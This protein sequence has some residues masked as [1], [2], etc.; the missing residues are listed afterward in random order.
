MKLPDVS[1][2]SVRSGVSGVRDNTA[3]VIKM[4]MMIPAQVIMTRE[5]HGSSVYPSKTDCG[6]GC[7]VLLFSDGQLVFEIKSACSFTMIYD[8]NVRSGLMP[9]F[10][11]I[12]QVFVNVCMC[13][14]CVRLSPWREFSMCV[15]V[16]WCE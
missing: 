6:F 8:K 2:R 13:D 4:I 10:E 1:L 5:K 9:S 11:C 16:C 7:A 3:Q 15:H 12:V 14:V